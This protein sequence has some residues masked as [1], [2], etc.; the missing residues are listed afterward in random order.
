MTDTSPETDLLTPIVSRFLKIDDLTWGDPKLNY[1]VRYR[2][3][4]YGEDSAAAYDQLASAL[5]PMEITPLFRL[6]GQKHVILLMK[7]VNRPKDSKA[8]VN[9]VL[10]ALTVLSVILAGAINAYQGPEPSDP[11]ELA[12]NLLLSLWKGIPFA[13]SLLAILLAHEFGHYLAARFHKTK[14][15]LPYFIPFP[16]SLFGT[17][18]A[19]ISIKE[20]PKNRRAMLDIGIAG[21]LAGLVVT[22]PVLLLGL[23]LSPVEPLPEQPAEEAGFVLEGNSALYL[24]A[25]YAVKGE[26]LPKPEETPT[27]PVLYWVRY[28]FTGS[29]IPWGG[30]DVMMHP[31]AW[32]GWA[33]LLVTSLNLIPAG[34]LDGG[35]LMYVLLG[36]KAIRFVPFIIGALILLGFIWNGWWLWAALIFFLGRA[37]MEPL[38]LITP[39]DVRRKALAVLGV[40]VFFMVFTPVP[41]MEI[42]SGM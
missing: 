19:F 1:I 7:G 10:F 39:L 21:P 4:L 22:I 15:T 13:A 29:P 24:M 17:M 35:H 30:K 27:N 5:R 2:G 40:I 12:Y 23:A 25:K 42:F 31:I 11:T 8:W 36:R 32:A 16:F 41:L 38:D 34:Q 6:D 33:G 18:G 37:Y 26:L 28:V 14:V 20:L 3:V 9:I